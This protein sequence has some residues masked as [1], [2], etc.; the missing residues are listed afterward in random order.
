MPILYWNFQIVAKVLESPNI[1]SD[2]DMEKI[3]LKA[4]HMESRERRGVNQGSSTMTMVEDPVKAPS[5]SS[6]NAENAA[7]T[8]SGNEYD[9]CSST[10]DAVQNN[11]DL[12]ATQGRQHKYKD[13]KAGGSSTQLNGN[14][15]GKSVAEIVRAQREARAQN[16]K[17][18]TK[19]DQSEEDQPGN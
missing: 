17:P 2:I 19:E 3:D 18:K 7:N 10:D 12:D 15:T 9:N 5:T 6:K 11:G 16:T 1:P 13:Q 4:L 14:G 8:S